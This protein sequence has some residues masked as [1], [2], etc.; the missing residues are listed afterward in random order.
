[1]VYKKGKVLY[2]NELTSPEDIND[3]IVEGEININWSDGMILSSAKDEAID[4]DNAH[5]VFWLNKDFGDRFIVEWE[6]TPLH[7]PGL[8]MFFFAASGLKGEDLFCETLATRTGYYPQYHS[9]DIQTYHL[10]YFRRKW[11]DERHFHTCNLRKS[12]G[13]YLLTQAP[14]PIPNVT[15]V[16]HSYQIRLTKN[17]AEI[18]FE[19]DDLPVLRYYDKEHGQHL[20]AGKIGF[21]QM[22]PMVAKYKNLRITEILES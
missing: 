15:D 7:E 6:F 13:F 21:R 9:G 3:F 11:D 8:C 1:M 20:K 12:A 5:W 18:K 19:I 16:M 22:A 14:D 4:G 17:G 10:S 2:Q